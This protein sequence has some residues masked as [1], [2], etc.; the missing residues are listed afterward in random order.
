MRNQLTINNLQFTIKHS[1]KSGFTVAE[2]L[3]YMGLMA[4]FLVVL[5]SV[6]TT[7]LNTKLAT[8][9]TSGV[10]TDSRYILSKLSYDVGN[11][12]SITSPVLGATAAS[13]QLVA[14][15]SANTYALNSGN[16][17]KTVGGVSMSLNGTDTQFDSI[18]F[19]NIGNPSGKPTIQVVYTIRSKIIVQGGNTQSL[20]VNTTVGTR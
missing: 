11:A 17:V 13:L 12:D 10:S 4:I 5:L 2:L 6:F 8:E 16:L 20:T 14:S 7:S 3:V 19:K 18:S 1:N 15:G 9:S